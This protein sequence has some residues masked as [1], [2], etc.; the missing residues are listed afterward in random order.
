M[1]FSGGVRD[2]LAQKFRGLPAT[3]GVAASGVYNF[4]YITAL[5]TFVNF[6]KLCHMRSPCLF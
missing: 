4:K 2:A 6:K 1:L 5:F 3:G